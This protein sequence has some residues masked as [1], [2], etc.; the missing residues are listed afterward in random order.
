MAEMTVQEF[1]DHVDEIIMNLQA[2]ETAIRFSSQ[3]RRPIPSRS[4]GLRKPQ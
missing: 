1:N 3:E 2:L 4:Q